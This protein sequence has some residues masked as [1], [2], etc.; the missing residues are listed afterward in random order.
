[1]ATSNS[2]RADLDPNP[3]SDRRTMER[4]VNPT[5]SPAPRGPFTP[6]PLASTSMTSPRPGSMA[7]SQ[8]QAFPYR[9]H[10][11]CSKHNTILSLT[12]DIPPVLPDFG[13]NQPGQARGVY[14]ATRAGIPFASNPVDPKVFGQTVAR[15]SCGNLGF[16]KAQRGTFEAAT[17]TASKMFELIDGLGYAGD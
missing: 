9:L 15:T 6:F 11:H 16:K 12:R 13:D 2:V 14:N 4:L 10:A 8:I 17:R 1:M 7:G 5:P 3:L